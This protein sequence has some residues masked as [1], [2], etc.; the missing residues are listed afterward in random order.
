VNP[1]QEFF[2]EVPHIA[3]PVDS[4]PHEIAFEDEM[5]IKVHSWDS[6]HFRQQRRPAVIGIFPSL[7]RSAV[8]KM[9]LLNAFPPGPSAECFVVQARSSEILG[10]AGWQSNHS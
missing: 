4:S 6:K 5:S 10:R 1:G 8:A 9:A 3:K 7:C 2:C